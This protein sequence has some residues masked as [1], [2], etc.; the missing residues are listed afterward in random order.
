MSKDERNEIIVLLRKKYSLHDIGLALKRSG[1]TIHY[2]IHNKSVR[3]QYD[4]AKAQLKTYVRR[5][6]ASFRGKSITVSMEL[7]SFVEKYLLDGQSP[8]AISGRIKHQEKGLGAVS[9]DT[10]YR[11]LR[12]PY[13]K[14]IGLKLKKKKRL[15]RGAKK[16]QLTER[17]FIDK[18]PK[19]IENRARAGDAE[20]DFIVSGKTGRGVLLVVACRK[21]RV[22]FLEI[23]HDVSIDEVHKAFLKIQGRFPELKTITLDNDILFRMHKTLS[24][25]L[26]GKI[27]FCHAYHSWDKG[28]IENVNRYIRRY[29]LKG[30]DLSR[31]NKKEISLIEN[32][33]NSRFMKCL[34]YATPNEALAR[35]R[36]KRKNSQKAV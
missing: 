19:I 26:G 23:I 16:K 21:L 20:G 36:K 33:C 27:Y 8:E 15:K 9:K 13:G 32:E 5:H 7:R 35:Y 1:S 17:V 25:L 29:I 30:S 10:I 3:G 4:S 18:R 2:E 24:E 34:N 14:I 6:N 12:S 28:G 22:S 31:Y 11:Y